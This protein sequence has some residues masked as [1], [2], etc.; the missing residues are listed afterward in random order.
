MQ[1]QRQKEEEKNSIEKKKEN[2]NIENQDNNEE[3]ENLE[4]DNE[5]EN[6]NSDSYN[7]N[8][9]LEYE[10][11]DYEKHIDFLN[12]QEKCLKIKKLLVEKM[13]NNISNFNYINNINNIMRCT[14]L[15]Y[16]KIYYQ[17]NDMKYI[18][19]PET[20][21]DLDNIKNKISI[22][23]IIEK[24]YLS[25]WCMKKL[26]DIQI[27]SEQILKLIAIGTSREQ[28]I[29]LNTINF[30]FY[31]M[32]KEHNGI[33][34]SLDQYKNDTKYF[35]SSSQDGTLNIYKLDNNYKY[36]LYQKLEKSEDK[37]GHEINKVIILSNELLVSSDR[38]SITIWK[39]NNNEKDKIQYEDFYEIIINNDT[40]QLLEINP[41]IFIATQYKSNTFQVYKNDGKTFPLIGELKNIGTHGKSSNGLCKINDKLVCSSSDDQF[42]I[43]CIDPIQVIQKHIINEGTIYYMYSTNDKYL[44]CSYGGYSII[45]YKILF[46]EDNNFVELLEIDKYNKEAKFL[47]EKAIL[48]FDDGRIFILANKQDSKYYQLID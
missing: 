36:T 3:K 6:E 47:N 27:S 13:S 5:N 40:C 32:I 23:S 48:P 15:K 10:V 44:Y 30:K 21:D 45:Q 16:I 35:F 18:D 34:Y 7:Y 29:L 46:D 12:K 37:K 11:V 28:I 33:V 31:Q 17:E 41:S 43:I 20:K 1:K 19:N 24:R 22:K 9:D 38:R 25:A 14:V 2:E 42:Y 4:N 39:S 26:N 8:S